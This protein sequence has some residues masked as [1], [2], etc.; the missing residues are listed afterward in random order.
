[1]MFLYIIESSFNCIPGDNR[2][3]RVFVV[4]EGY[5]DAVD[6]FVVLQQAFS[7]HGLMRVEQLP[8]DDEVQ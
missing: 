5:V 6:E 7:L 1:M 8:S 3:L 4:V 2:N